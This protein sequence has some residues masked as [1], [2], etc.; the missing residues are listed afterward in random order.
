M[1]RFFWDSFFKRVRAGY[2][3]DFGCF[4]EVE[5]EF[6]G[7]RMLD[8]FYVILLCLM[9]LGERPLLLLC[10]TVLLLTLL[11]LVASIS[12]LLCGGISSMES[13]L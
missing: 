11:A 1:P 6:F 5:R 8:D 10:L 2:Y 12:L 13:M 9:E 4:L 7:R 3:E